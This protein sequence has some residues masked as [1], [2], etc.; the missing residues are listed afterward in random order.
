MFKWYPM[1]A[2]TGYNYTSY[3]KIAQFQFINVKYFNKA[4]FK[5]TDIGKKQ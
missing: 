2:K 4:I 3:N 1:R 5:N